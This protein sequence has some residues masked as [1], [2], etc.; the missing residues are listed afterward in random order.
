MDKIS[1]GRQ[2]IT[3][4]NSTK[5]KT[6]S[7]SHDVLPR[8]FY[9]LNFRLSGE[10][11]FHYNGRTVFSPAETLLYVP[12]GA[13]YSYDASEPG[14]IVSAHFNVAEPPAPDRIIGFAPENPAVFKA[15]YLSMTDNLNRSPAATDAD[16]AA[17][18][19]FALSDFY[20][21]LGLIE[22]QE[23]NAGENARLHPLIMPAVE[24]MNAG[25]SDN[26]LSVAR[27][28]GIAGL[29]EPY[30]RRVFKKLYGRTPSEHICWL[31]VERA[32]EL[33]LAGGLGV[34]KIAQMCGFSNP[35]YFCFVFRRETGV[36]PGE[37][38]KI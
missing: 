9:A 19:L 27:L 29:S 20:K 17:R 12:R 1:I 8:P 30:F 3:E 18:R 10:I 2:F 5:V 32:K 14:A 23:V 16:R 31:R 25:I 35:N 4:L 24:H 28:A 26:Q 33:L 37:F 6:L 7:G 11:Y 36:S 21:I 34:A 22:K 13:G 38:T 15:L